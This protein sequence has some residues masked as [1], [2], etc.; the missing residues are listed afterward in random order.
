MTLLGMPLEQAAASLGWGNLMDF[1]R[2]LPHESATFRALHGDAYAFSCDLK[3]AAMLADAIDVLN[4]IAYMYSKAHN[5][6]PRKPRPY[7]RPWE[8]GDEQ[9]IGA[10]PIPI[11]EFNR[12]YYGGDA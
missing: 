4:G 2:H 10:D 7:P 11:S 3:R 8:P 6:K 9:R 12:W 1:E 5:G